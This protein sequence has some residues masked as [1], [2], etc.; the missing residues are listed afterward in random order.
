MQNTEQ[1]GNDDTTTK[2]AIVLSQLQ[3]YLLNDY[4]I[5]VCVCLRARKSDGKSLPIR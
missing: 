1:N 5:C 4:D 3:E 2:E